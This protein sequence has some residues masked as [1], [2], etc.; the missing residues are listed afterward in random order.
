MFSEDLAALENLTEDSILNELHERLKI[1]SFHTFVGDIL[2][3]LNPNEEL[4]IYGP[5]VSHI[6]K[7]QHGES[8]EAFAMHISSVSQ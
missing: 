5:K 3:L 2:L 4:D 1:G 6:F 7:I 8:A